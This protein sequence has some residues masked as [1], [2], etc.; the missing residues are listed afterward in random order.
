MGQYSK[1][2]ISAVI[3]TPVEIW[4]ILGM[5]IL[6]GVRSLKKQV[7]YPPQLL[8][9]PATLMCF[10]FP[11]FFNRAPYL[12]ISMLAVGLL[13]GVVAASHMR[14]SWQKFPRRLVLP[15]GP[16][17]LWILCSFF[18]IKYAYGILHEIDQVQSSHWAWIDTGVSGLLPGYSWAKGLYFSYQYFFGHQKP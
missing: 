16:S 11:I 12:Y 8:L 6:F 18:C 14:I 5:M 17:T 13:I 9:I 15:G 4:I 2:V 7:I 1:S 10:K 3:H